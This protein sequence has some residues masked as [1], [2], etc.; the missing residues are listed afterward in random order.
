MA[1][2]D[3]HPPP[4]FFVL[5]RD[6]IYIFIHGWENPVTDPWNVGIFLPT[7]PIKNNHSCT[8]RYP[9]FMDPNYGLQATYPYHERNSKF[10]SENWAKSW[11]DRVPNINFQLSFREGYHFVCL[12]GD[13]TDSTTW[14]SSPLNSAPFNG[15]ILG[16]IFSNPKDLGPSFLEGWKN[17]YN[18]QGL[19]GVLKMTPVTW[20]SLGILREARN[21]QANLSYHFHVGN[22]P[23][24]GWPK[25]KGNVPPPKTKI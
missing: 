8:D 22:A 17:L 10:A 1:K 23:S 16:D 11:K 12:S 3:G 7:N 18:S 19:F 9:S 13:F 21:Q 20:G 25:S 4:Y 24:K 15:K 6:I 5:L 14:H 2:W